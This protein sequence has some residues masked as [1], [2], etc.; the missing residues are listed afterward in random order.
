RPR[1]AEIPRP[2]NRRLKVK[3]PIDDRTRNGS[4]RVC[5]AKQEAVLDP[6][7][8]ADIVGNDP[9]KAHRERGILESWRETMSRRPRRR[10]GLPGTPCERGLAANFGIAI[11]EKLI[12]GIDD[13]GIAFGG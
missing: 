8:V 1:F 9:R 5:V 7:I 2:R 12:D 4:E 3:A 11:V 13:V 10:R 6:C